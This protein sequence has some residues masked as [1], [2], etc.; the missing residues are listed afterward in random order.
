MKIP[1]FGTLGRD[2]DRRDEELDE[3]LSTHLEMAAADRVADGETP[4]EA[5]A[6]ARREF[7]N[8][9]LV[10]E[11]TR[12]AW[13][14]LWLETLGQDLRFGF[15]MLRRN[16]GFS[17]LAVLCLTLGIGG[18]AAVC[19]WI[20]GILLRPYPGVARQETLLVL[21][22]TARGEVGH[23]AVSWPDIV[24][25]RRRTT[26]FESIIAEKITGTTLSVGDHAVR[27][28]G[29]IVSANY[30]EAL[31][32]RP[33]LGRGFEPA[34]ELGRNAHPVTV[35]SDQLWKTRFDGDPAIIGKKQ[36]FNGVP[37]TIVGVA[38]EGFYGTFVG[39]PFQFWVPLSMQETFDSTG[40]K[41][42][43]R[44]ERWI[45]GFVRVK[46]GVTRQ[47]AEAEISAVAK[48][49]EEE[50]PGTNRGHGVRLTPIWQS[51]FNG[52]G[53]LFPTLRIAL[54]VV[55]FVLLIACANVGNL[56]LV[57]SLARRHEMTVRLAIG[58]G[59][60][61]LVRQ[62]LTEGLILTSIASAAGLVL[63]YVLRDFMLVLYPP[64]GVPMRLSGAID[65][66]VLA[67]CA[68]VCLVSTLLVGLVPALQAGKV[69]LAGALKSESAGVVGGAG[70]LRLRSSLVLL[71]VSLSFLL[72]VGAGLLVESMRRIHRASPGF[73][74][75]G[76]LTTAV[77]LLSAGYDGARARTFQDE[78]MNRIRAIPGVESA[79]YSRIRPFSL[80]TY[81][82]TTLAVDGYQPVPDEQP[83]AEYNEI[84]PEFFATLG[85]PLVSGR[86][87]T[88]A[89][90][91][92]SRP[93]AIVDDTMA[94][95]F[96]PGQDPVGRLIR[97]PDR[98]L[99]VVGVAKAA[100][101]RTL[102]EAPKPFF[103]VPLRQNPSITVNVAIRTSRGVGPMATA[104]VRE[105]H[106]LDG[107]LALSELITMR[108]QVERSTA[109][110]R[111]AVTLLGLFGGLA[112]LLAA[113]GLYGVMSHSVSQSARELGLRMALGARASDLVRLVLSHGAALAAAGVGLGAAAA[114]LS[115]RLLGYLL[116]EVS[117]RDPLAFGSAFGVMAVAALAACLVPALRATRTDPV[118]AL[119]A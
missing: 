56:L 36:I 85:I 16:P 106:A 109:P 116:Y 91:E 76:V 67:A 95:H 72:L 111:I 29:S 63:A 6:G 20:E 50:Y 47:Q 12:E 23:T 13:G 119:R 118:R 112:L 1:G 93:V 9:G 117:P 8:V 17:L 104:L 26:L 25:F 108:E 73:A 99:E 53:L 66:R 97:L 96:W 37:H 64:L 84:S 105:I 90:D 4:A 94:R 102:L 101:Y 110:Q 107:N 46:P 98:V 33:Q 92:H 75:D 24:D 5:A 83:A 51:P 48:Q 44:G 55:L 27:I 88:R 31:G 86:A 10:K 81:S 52:A 35:I 65:A 77:D 79:A 18:S 2:R 32:V 15:R 69:D 114:L 62:L 61:R 57:Q 74:T 87:F 3:E 115:T 11:I 14:G 42:E 59:R 60:G 28:P 39:Y 22:G 58:A 103:Y 21:V 70:R 89:D 82:E 34:E 19:G 80:R 40:Y 43:S 38:P 41:V 68:G 30:F 49:L 45:E 78:L 7:G 113:I 54:G 71:Q 100:K